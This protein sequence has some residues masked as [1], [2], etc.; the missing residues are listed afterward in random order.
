MRYTLL[1]FLLCSFGCLS[2]AQI[3]IETKLDSSYIL[4]GEQVHLTASISLDSNQKA[5]FPEFENG[6][7]TVVLKKAE[8]YLA[9]VGDVL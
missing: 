9:Y 7:L 8:S 2:H 1:F 5:V 3:S 6:Y 4:I